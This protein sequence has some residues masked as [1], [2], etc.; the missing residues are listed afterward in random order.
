[1]VMLTDVERG[2]LDFELDPS[3]RGVPPSAGRVLSSEISARVWHPADGA[4]NLPMLTVDLDAYA[5]NKR[6]MLEICRQFRSIIAPH[7]KTPMS[8]V[9]AR[10]LIESGAWGASVADLRQASA[11][12]RYGIRRIVIANEIGG[13]AAATRLAGLLSSFRDADIYLY[14]D[15][16]ELMDAL[17]AVWAAEASL[18]RLQLLIEIGC[19]RGGVQTQRKCDELIEKWCRLNEPRIVLAG[20]AAYEGTVNTPDATALAI[21][22][23]DL[24]QRMGDALKSVRAAVGEAPQLMLSAG[25][26]SLFDHVIVRSIPIVEADGNSV[27]QLRSGSC[28][29]SDHGPTR[30]RLAALARRNLLGDEASARVAQ[31]FKPALR[32][33]AEVLSA[34][35]DVSFICGLGL[36][37]AAHD[38]GLPVPLAV[39]RSGK[40]IAILTEEARVTKLNDQHAFVRAHGLT[41]KVGD[42]L[43]FGVRHPCTTI[44]KHDLIFGL[45]ATD[46]ITTVFRTFFG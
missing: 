36:R 9:L 11:L 34:Q 8:P 14:V 23:D 27:L 41:V 45:G 24:F 7:A 10:D 32:L 42:V 30:D 37:D 16:T 38:Q 46:R 19:G 12:L 20:V 3:A 1:M 6:A 44:D 25:G 33:W 43:E 18:P 40:R 31:S 5:S 15:S 28:F 35:N 29:F 2:L 4:M 17:A 22:L 21:A 26:S 39:W 13:H